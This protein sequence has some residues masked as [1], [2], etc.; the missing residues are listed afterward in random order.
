LP[1]YFFAQNEFIFIFIF[2]ISCC[3]W[4]THC[5]F[6]LELLLVFNTA[7]YAWS[8]LLPANLFGINWKTYS[9]P[10][11]LNLLLVLTGIATPASATTGSNFQSL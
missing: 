7:D 2:A 11:K 3:Y 6:C 1:A 9:R 4:L 5:D 8:I 10:T